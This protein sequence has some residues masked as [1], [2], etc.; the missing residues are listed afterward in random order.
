MLLTEMHFVFVF[1][2]RG[3]WRWWLKII[4]TSGPRR[5]KAILEAEV[6]S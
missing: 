1:G 5:K 3:W 2:P 6:V 4:I